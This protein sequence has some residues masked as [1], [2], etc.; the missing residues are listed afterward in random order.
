MRISKCLNFSVQA[1]SRF[2]N[3]LMPLTFIKTVLYKSR[4]LCLTI[5]CWFFPVFEIVFF[6]KRK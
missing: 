6:L 1:F 4:P 3:I 2:V 5:H